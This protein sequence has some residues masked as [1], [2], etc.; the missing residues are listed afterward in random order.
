MRILFKRQESPVVIPEITQVPKFNIANEVITINSIDVTGGNGY[1]TSVGIPIKVDLDI[2][3][4]EGN[5][6]TQLDQSLL[7]VEGLKL[8][9]IK[10]LDGIGSRELDKIYFDVTL[11][12]GHV[13]VT[14]SFP[15]GGDWK[16]VEDKANKA[17]DDVNAGF[18][19]TR[20][21]LT[22]LV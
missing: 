21:P 13:E 2:V 12:E 3:D 5:V 17:L 14:G 7:P 4:T 10:Y 20:N 8:P 6:L 16:M 9:M 19:I 22:F 18:H 15:T 1:T 11:V